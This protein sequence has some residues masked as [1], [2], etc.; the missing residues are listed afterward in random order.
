MQFHCKLWHKDSRRLPGALHPWPES[1]AGWRLPK[2][3]LLVQTQ[4]MRKAA[5][6][7]GAKG[8]I[9]RVTERCT[10][11]ERGGDERESRPVALVPQGQ[12]LAGDGA[13][14]TYRRGYGV[15]SAGGWADGVMRGREGTSWQAGMRREERWG[16]ETISQRGPP[17]GSSHR[18]MRLG[19]TNH[20]CAT[21]WANGAGKRCRV[22]VE[23]LGVLERIFWQSECWMA[24][25]RPQNPP[26]TVC[27]RQ[28]QPVRRHAMC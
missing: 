24:Q 18:W 20:L 22:G 16:S 11:E 15:P 9:I 17:S 1:T 5:Q 21:M 19:E 10:E 8:R 4:G 23:E 2:S 13:D 12:E 25:W 3:H 7:K 28:C 26:K 27:A 6:K 14:G